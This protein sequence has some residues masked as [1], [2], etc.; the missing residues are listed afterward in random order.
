MAKQHKLDH[1]PSIHLIY[2]YVLGQRYIPFMRRKW[3]GMP[4]VGVR[5][6]KYQREQHKFELPGFI[7]RYNN[8]RTI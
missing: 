8:E 5:N 3:R 4:C 7:W 1:D 2:S 6:R